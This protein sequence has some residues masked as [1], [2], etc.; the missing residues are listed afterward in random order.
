MELFVN[1]W[2]LKIVFLQKDSVYVYARVR[3]CVCVLVRVCVCVRWCPNEFQATSKLK[4]KATEFDRLILVSRWRAKFLSVCCQMSSDD[5]NW[6]RHSIYLRDPVD[7]RIFLISCKKGKVEFAIKCERSW[8]LFFFFFLAR[9]TDR[10]VDENA[11]AKV[12]SKR[13]VATDWRIA[14]H[15]CTGFTTWHGISLHVLEALPGTD[16]DPPG[17][18]KQVDFARFKLRHS[19]HV[20]QHSNLSVSFRHCGKIWAPWCATQWPW[21][22]SS[23]A[24][25]FWIQS[26]VWSNTKSCN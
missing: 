7:D 9:T 8:K 5:R 3:V 21:Q 11:V 26:V 23:A 16:I 14:W 20:V 19:S 1:K 4:V 25:H 22:Q 24:K 10:Q 12:S 18:R 17:L 6:W 2:Q 13:R 15:R